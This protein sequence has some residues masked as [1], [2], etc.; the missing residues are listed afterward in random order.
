MS[1]VLDKLNEDEIAE[2]VAA[3]LGEKGL[4]A[5]AVDTGGGML[6]V[7]LERTTGGEIVWGTADVTWGAIITDDE[8][9]QVSAIETSCPSDSQDIQAIAAALF[10]PSVTNGATKS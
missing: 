3:V 8:G 1:N 6:C 5:G 10:E 9:E 7:V 4:V 2:A